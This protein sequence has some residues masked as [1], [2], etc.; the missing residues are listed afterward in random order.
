MATGEALAM[1]FVVVAVVG[2]C[3]TALLFAFAFL[4]SVCNSLIISC[5]CGS[6]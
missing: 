2:V 3:F 6:Q 4:N 1:T 5:V